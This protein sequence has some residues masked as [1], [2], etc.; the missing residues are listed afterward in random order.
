MLAAL[1]AGGVA[2]AGEALI[3]ADTLSVQAGIASGEGGVRV[4]IQ[5]QIATGQSFTYDLERGL[6]IVRDGAWSRPEGTVSFSRAEI[7]VADGAGIALEGRYLGRDGRLSVSGDRL[8]WVDEGV[9]E[10]ERVRLTTC[11]C[12]R[13]TWSVSAAEVR[14]TLDE[15][16]TFR[17]AWISLCEQ[18]LVPVPAGRL[19]LSDRQSGLLAPDLGLGEDGLRVAV[20]V[21]LT[22]G[23]HAD[24]TLSP[25]LRTARSARLLSEVR[26]ALPGRDGGTARAAAGW[27]WKSAAARGALDVDH[28]SAWGRARAGVDALWWSDPD[29]GEDYGDSWF[30]RR[31]PWTEARALGAWGPLAVETD[32]FQAEEAM[33][34]RPVSAVLR[35]VGALGSVSGRAEARLDG[36][37]EG[38]R[39]AA[40]DGLSPRALGRASAAWGADLGVIE[41]LARGQV[42]AVARADE[43]PWAQGSAGLDLTLPLWWSGRRAL[44][45]LDVGGAGLISHTLGDAQPVLADEALAP[46]WSAGPTLR[47]TALSRAGV[48]LSATLRLPWTP[49]GLAPQAELRLRHGP[50]SATGSGD[51]ALQELTLGRD[52][53]S[54]ALGLGAAR[55]TDLLQARVSAAVPLPGPLS[56]W[57]PSASALL[58]LEAPAL[59][60][61]S[62]GLRFRPACDCVEAELSGALSEDRAWPDLSFRLQIW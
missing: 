38:A 50:W 23:P 52:D 12:A 54:L 10:G 16:A 40:L 36:L 43:A 53:G 19:A 41:A 47:A 14:V 26:Y 32:S 27:D 24:L 4:T 58:D 62:L 33:D 22:L 17:G 49:E 21:Y 11:A 55:A 6:L 25:E 31:A 34:Q 57:R 1:L 37:S 7:Q 15:V 30:S 48:P 35:G 45:L 28:A 3:E 61:T 46:A 51:R 56:A 18:P 9:I 29:Y 8:V 39:L 2:R 13:P 42:G 20:P 5:D 60:S 59:L 44:W